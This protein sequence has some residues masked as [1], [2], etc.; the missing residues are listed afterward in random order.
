MTLVL[1]EDVVHIIASF[2]L[3]IKD[4]L[5]MSITC[6]AW[7]IPGQKYAYRDHILRVEGVDLHWLEQHELLVSNHP[8][9]VAYIKIL[10][11]GGNVSQAF[12]TLSLHSVV[13]SLQNLP[14][15][16]QL[17]IT[18]VNWYTII[19]PTPFPHFPSLHKLYM[20]DI[21]V[22]GEAIDIVQP[23]QP[24]C[25]ASRWTLIDISNVIE[26]NHGVFHL[27]GLFP[28]HALRVSNEPY[29]IG[30][31]LISFLPALSDVEDLVLNNYTAEDFRAVNKLFINNASSLRSLWFDVSAAEPSQFPYY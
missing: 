3:V 8:T 28:V 2:V 9:M 23:L 7:K 5:A 29:R 15:V 20:S 11:I 18:A 22:S 12:P 31:G 1:P 13:R 26:W 21:F 6:K 10:R 16:V 27:E 24:L 30:T 4:L 25:L 19:P 14:N 17:V